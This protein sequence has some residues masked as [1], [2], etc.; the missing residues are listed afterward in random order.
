MPKRPS[1]DALDAI[2]SYVPP[3]AVGTEVESTRAEERA[4]LRLDRLLGEEPELGELV[5]AV[6][7]ALHSA[8]PCDRVGI[9]LVDREESRIVLAAA[10]AGYRP[11]ALVAGY[12]EPLAGTSL[13]TVWRT[14]QARMIRDLPAYLDRHPQSASS[15]L[16]VSEGILS[17]LTT[18]LHADGRCIG[19]LLRSSRSLRAFAP[20]HLAL[21]W[22]IGDR[23]AGVVEQA[24]RSEQLRTA[25]RAYGELL[26]FVS[27]E[28]KSPLA[29]IVMDASL[30]AD[31][32]LGPL[33]ERQQ[34]SL[35]QIVRRGEALMALVREYLELARIE[36][37]TVTPALRE[38]V[39]PLA[40]I[41]L[42]AIEQIKAPLGQRRMTLVRE[43][44]PG[45]P[46]LTC[47][48]TM[49]RIALVNLLGN[50]VK[51]G[52]DEGQVRLTLAFDAKSLQFLVWNEGIG[53]PETERARLFRRFSRL[54][55]PELRAREG[56][57]VGLYIAA[58]LVRMH[59]GWMIAESEPGRWA[60]F[61]FAIP[62]KGESTQPV[63]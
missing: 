30:L 51:Y 23:L 8:G 57:G 63:S 62:L 11:L 55:V 16:L 14:G 20:R 12:E 15:R 25:H 49:L 31:G 44:P 9:A 50:A 6:Y 33:T 48:P 61:G 46:T 32:Y 35:Q 2:V 17:S 5:R 41:A 19:F 13:E 47:D 43:F 54:D 3:P 22:A 26:T 60:R 4:L 42:P 37:G 58:R 38:A 28:L 40:S 52:R 29:S 21:Q 36:S 10:H 27:H 53:F 34:G 56:T 24:R 1:S 59:G 39:E 7:D 45:L 18:P